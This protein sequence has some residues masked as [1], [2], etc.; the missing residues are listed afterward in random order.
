MQIFTKKKREILWQNGHN[1][2]EKIM[3]LCKKG[4][5]REQKKDD[6]KKNILA[7]FGLWSAISIY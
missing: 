2:G 5:E 6:T 7:V 4:I 3:R 1:T